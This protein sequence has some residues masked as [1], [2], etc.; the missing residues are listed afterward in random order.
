MDKTSIKR[1]LTGEVVS[2]KMTKAIVVEVHSV[3]VHPKYH[4]R[5]RVTK[6]YPAAVDEGTYAVGDKVE[7]QECAPRS[8][9]INWVVVRKIS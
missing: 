3:K 8:K 6:R 2:A 4:K 9:T 5:Y 1:K 7:I